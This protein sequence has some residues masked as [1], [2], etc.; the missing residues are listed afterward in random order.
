MNAC[1]LSCWACQA[2]ALACAA[3][4]AAGAGL[5]MHWDH[6]RMRGVKAGPVTVIPPGP[7]EVIGM[8]P[9]RF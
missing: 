3:V 2:R 6:R 5:E 9:R 7:R 1:A 4:K 8:S